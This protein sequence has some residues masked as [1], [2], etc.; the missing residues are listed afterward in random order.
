IISALEALYIFLRRMSY[1]AR[2]EDL[3]N[4]FGRAPAALISISNA[5]QD[6]LFDSFSHLL[7]FDTR[8]LTAITLRAYAGSVCR[9]KKNQKYVFNGHKKHALMY[10]SFLAPDGIIIHISGPFPGTRH[11]VFILHQSLLLKVAASSLTFDGKHYVFYGDSAYGQQ[12]H[13]VAPF[14]T[15]DVLLVTVHTCLYRS[16][17]SKYSQ[18]TPPSVDEYLHS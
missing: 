16:Q 5:V 9:P 3:A 4:L 11:D 13:V 7:L 1:P 14:Y 12:E 8:R 6:F 17:A 10:Q 18:H 2:L 15:M